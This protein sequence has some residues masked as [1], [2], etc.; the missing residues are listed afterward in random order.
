MVSIANETVASQYGRIS[1]SLDPKELIPLRF[2]GFGVSLLDV[3]AASTPVL[4]GAMLLCFSLGFGLVMP[5]LDTSV[6]G[7]VSSQFR[8][9][10]LG[11]LTSMLWL[12][13][14]VGPITF[15]GIVSTAFDEPVTGYRFLLLCCG[16]ASLVGGVLV[17]LAFGRR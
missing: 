7:L 9:S 10:M 1:R 13:Q 2:V 12:G 17:L 6:V 3:W 8:A 16:M 5:S 14:T 11:V 4:I 15:T